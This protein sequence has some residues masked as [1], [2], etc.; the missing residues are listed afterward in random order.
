MTLDYYK[1]NQVDD[2]YTK[3]AEANKVDGLYLDGKTGYERYYIDMQ[4]FW[5]ELYDPNPSISYETSGG[6]YTTVKE[7]IDEAEGTYKMV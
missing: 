2:F 5:R 1:Y 3:V 4:G 7:V 6:Y